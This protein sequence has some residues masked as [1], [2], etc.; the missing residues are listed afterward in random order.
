VSAPFS[1]EPTVSPR[2]EQV[3]RAFAKGDAT[4]RQLADCLKAESTSV[5]FDSLMEY[6]GG[7]WP[8]AKIVIRQGSVPASLICPAQSQLDAAKHRLVRVLFDAVDTFDEVNAEFFREYPISILALRDG[9]YAIMDG[10]HRVLR[11]H[12]L[13]GDEEPLHVTVLGTHNV[14]LCNNYRR[15]VENVAAAIGSFHV[16][17]LP[18]V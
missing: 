14:E 6:F 5:C 18:I 16:K 10:H 1:Q 11:W 17:D 15:Q 8:E 3:L 13:A 9:R 7:L 2:A 12:E 4:R